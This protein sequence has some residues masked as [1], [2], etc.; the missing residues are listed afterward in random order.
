MVVLYIIALIVILVACGFTLRLIHDYKHQASHLKSDIIEADDDILF[1]NKESNKILNQTEGGVSE[2]TSTLERINRDLKHL[3]SKNEGVEQQLSDIATQ[4][5]PVQDGIRDMLRAAGAIEWLDDEIGDN[6]TRI[7]NLSDQASGVEAEIVKIVQ[8]QDEVA[9]Y[10]NLLQTSLSKYQNNLNTINPSLTMLSK[11]EGEIMGDI[12]SLKK[13]VNSLQTSLGPFQTYRITAEN[14]KK[15]INNLASSLNDPE[16]TVG[17]IS[18]LGSQVEILNTNLK[19]SHSQYSTLNPKISSD[20]QKL[21][22][23]VNR[24]GGNI[25]IVNGIGNTLRTLQDTIPALNT[26]YNDV[27][28]L[29]NAIL[30]QTTAINSQSTTAHAMV[31]Q[32]DDISVDISSTNDKLPEIEGLNGIIS[33]IDVQLATAKA[34][35]AQ[36]EA[37]FTTR[38]LCIDDVCID[39]LELQKSINYA[40]QIRRVA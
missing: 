2:A 19:G 16:T 22:D 20:F 30:T 8:K 1:I 28:P 24:A 15:H 11:T 36:H 38:K 7:T 18:N 5:T 32:F 6:H 21:S 3:V 14:T 9:L 33:T 12:T 27:T 4:I 13:E 29:S 35:Q 31:K 26:E 34:V 39:K 10:V 37:T 40:N 23:D 25:G 17:Y